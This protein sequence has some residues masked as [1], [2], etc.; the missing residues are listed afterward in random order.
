MQK[1]PPDAVPTVGERPKRVREEDATDDGNALQRRWCAKKC[2]AHAWLRKRMVQKHAEK[3]LLGG[4]AEAQDTLG[5]GGEAGQG[6]E[7][8]KEFVCE[9]CHR[10]LKS[11]AWLTRHKCAATSIINS[12]GSN[13]AEQPVTAARPIC[14][15]E[16]RYR[17][18]L[19]HML[20]KHPRHGEPSRP[21]P[22]AKPKQREMR[23]E[24]QT[25]GEGSGP[26]ESAE[27]G[28]TPPATTA[29]AP[30]LSNEARAKTV[31]RNAPAGK[32]W[33]T[34]T[35]GKAQL[36]EG[37]ARGVCGAPP[38]APKLARAK[39]EARTANPEGRGG[40]LQCSAC[41]LHEGTL[42]ARESICPHTS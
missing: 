19:R 3:R 18:L 26:L 5:S 6:E 27:G 39:E 22:R 20:A 10:V 21:Q 1:H 41:Q 42:R 16:C 11:K 24:A 4:A 30:I 2:A 34:E 33:P 12:E 37:V 35:G 38:G 9:Q 28:D 13:V 8:Q 40:V 17:R 14:S 15:E 7:E 25:Q 29:P 31:P 32:A 36:A 23:S